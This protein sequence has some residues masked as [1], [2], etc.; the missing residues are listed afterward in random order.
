MLSLISLALRLGWGGSLLFLSGAGMAKLNAGFD[1]DYGKM[2]SSLGSPFDQQPE[3]FFFALIFAE[4]VVP[5]LLIAGFYTRFA[6]TIGSIS[7]A[8]ACHTHLNVW[9]QDFDT[10]LRSSSDPSG[11]GSFPF[12]IVAALHHA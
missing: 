11:I 6:A 12:F 10:I 3:F 8:V 4:V 5:V 9:G 2:V 1:S 7:F